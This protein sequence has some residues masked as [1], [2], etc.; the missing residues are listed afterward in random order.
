MKLVKIGILIAGTAEALIDK[1]LNCSTSSLVGES[2]YFMQGL[3]MLIFPRQ[4]Y[5]SAYFRC[6]PEF[7]AA[8]QTVFSFHFVP[9]SSY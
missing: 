5:I 7:L 1:C 2:F 6:L 9:F 3:R 8:R 4:F